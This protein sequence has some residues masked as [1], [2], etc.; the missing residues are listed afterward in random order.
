MASTPAP[1]GAPD[2][3]NF[4]LVITSTTEPGV[5][6][7]QQILVAASTTDFPNLLTVGATLTGNLDHSPGWWVFREAGT[8]TTT[9]TRNHDNYNAGNHDNY[10]AGNNDNYYAGTTTTTTPVTTTTTTTTPTTTTTT[11]TPTTTT[12]TTPT[13]T[14]TTTTAALAPVPLGTAGISRF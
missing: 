8:I 4:Y 9:T 1:S 10:D 13:T 3:Y 12:T 6:A 2:E 5:T 7:G 14:T 11:T